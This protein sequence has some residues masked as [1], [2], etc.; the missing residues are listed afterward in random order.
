MPPSR[1]VRANQGGLHDLVQVMF[2]F[3][4]LERTGFTRSNRNLCWQSTREN[5]QGFYVS[6]TLAAWFYVV[7]TWH[8]NDEFMSSVCYF[9]ENHPNI[10]VWEMCIFFGARTGKDEYHVIQMCF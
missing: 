8:L 4:I 6:S 3:A 2:D 9:Y 7:W 5:N 10:Y 1:L